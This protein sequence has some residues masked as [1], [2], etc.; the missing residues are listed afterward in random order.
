M[1][2]QKKNRTS[3]PLAPAQKPRQKNSIREESRS[4]RLKKHKGLKSGSR[5]A[6]EANSQNTGGSQQQQD[7]RHGS[8]TPISLNP[9]KA[10]EKIRDLKPQ[11]VLTKNPTLPVDPEQELLAIEND[12][13]L[14]ALLERVDNDEVLKGKDAKYFN[15]AT[16][17]HQALM[18]Q[19]GF[20]NDDD[21]DEEEED[22]RSLAEQ[23]E[24]DD[25]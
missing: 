13:R 11:V 15:A 22:S 10:P 1:T 14:L 20:D 7:P 23:W 9:A 8:T 17:R 21:E 4:Q 6:Q 12:E 18:E 19:L 16:A 2:R 24:D 25:E 3:G 5:N